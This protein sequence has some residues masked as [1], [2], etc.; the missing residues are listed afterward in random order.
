MKSINFRMGYLVLSLAAFAFSGLGF[1]GL[2][3]QGDMNGKQSV[4]FGLLFLS[5]GIFLGSCFFKNA[6]KH[7]LRPPQEGNNGI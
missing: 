6:N 7:P 1:A 5:A 2:L 3:S 4:Y